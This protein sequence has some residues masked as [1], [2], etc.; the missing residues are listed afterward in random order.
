MAD[1][2]ACPNVDISYNP[3]TIIQFGEALTNTGGFFNP[4]TGIFT[5]PVDG[6]YYFFITIYT[7]NDVDIM[8]AIYLDG[9]RM[10]DMYSSQDG[11]NHGVTSLVTECNMFQGVWVECVDNSG[12]IRGNRF[13]SFSGFLL[14]EYAN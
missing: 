1:F 10:V 12:T 7:D 13:T 11:G 5:C 4:D 8:A 2:T 14:A 3:G 6:L 9:N